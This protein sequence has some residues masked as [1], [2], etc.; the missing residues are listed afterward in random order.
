ME[1][2]DTRVSA[3]DN[4]ALLTVFEYDVKDSEAK[5]VEKWIDVDH[6]GPH[7]DNADERDKQRIREPVTWRGGGN[8]Q[9][10]EQIRN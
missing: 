9:K 3:G 5:Q 10:W 1:S 4:Q 8:G 2:P 6:V 7:V